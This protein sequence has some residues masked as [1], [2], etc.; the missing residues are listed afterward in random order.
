MNTNFDFFTFAAITKA[1]SYNGQYFC[2]ASSHS[3]TD[4][5]ENSFF[6]H[7]QSVDAVN[8]FNM[9]YNGINIIMI[10]DEYDAYNINTIYAAANPRKNYQLFYATIN[11]FFTEKNLQNC[12]FSSAMNNT[13]FVFHNLQYRSV[14]NKFATFNYIISGGSNNKKHILSPVQLRLA[15]FIISISEFANEEV[16]TSFYCDSPKEFRE[17]GLDFTHKY[18]K[19]ALSK[20][21][22]DVKKEVIND[23]QDLGSALVQAVKQEVG[24]GTAGQLKKE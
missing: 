15:R 13:I 22:D 16:A 1:K 21:T 12:M 10:S 4:K 3:W 11:G 24:S 20:L 17:E 18:V 9:L 8:R 6:Q 2:M 19:Y 5:E 7:I 14:V 23:Q